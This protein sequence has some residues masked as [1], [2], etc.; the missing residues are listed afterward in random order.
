VNQ[1]IKWCWR[2]RP[3]PVSR[4]CLCI[5]LRTKK[6]PWR[7]YSGWDL[8]HLPNM[9]RASPLRY[10]ARRV[11]Q[12]SDDSSVLGSGCSHTVKWSWLC[13]FWFRLVASRNV[14][15]VSS[16]LWRSFSDVYLFL[17]CWCL[18]LYFYG[19]LVRKFTRNDC[20]CTT[21]PL[22]NISGTVSHGSKI[23]VIIRMIY[24]NSCLF[25]QSVYVTTQFFIV[26]N[27]E[28]DKKHIFQRSSIL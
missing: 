1:R 19:F 7:G 24:R 13:S 15:W 18:T 25:L 9:L 11:Y 10:V 20:C 27:T 3:F 14:T 21:N 8:S 16:T 28:T 17:V 2:E 23:F 12:L 22:E 26:P 4:H 6:H 5:C